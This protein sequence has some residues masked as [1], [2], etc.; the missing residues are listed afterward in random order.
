MKTDNHT[1]RIY[2]FTTVISVLLISCSDMDKQYTAPDQKS[3]FEQRV[4]HMEKKKRLEMFQLQEEENAKQEFLMKEMIRIQD[5]IN[6]GYYHLAQKELKDL[7]KRYPASKEAL[8]AQELLKSVTQNLDQSPVMRQ[9]EAAIITAKEAEATHSIPYLDE[10]E[11]YSLIKISIVKGRNKTALTS[12]NKFLSTF[13]KSSKRKEIEKLKS[14]LVTS[15]QKDPTNKMTHTLP[16]YL[17][18]RISQMNDKELWIESQRLI[19][20]EKYFTAILLL[21]HLI[22]QF[23]ESTYVTQAKSSLPTLRI[24]LELNGN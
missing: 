21:E 9:F 17:K 13:P 15:V 4:E 2:L 5:S 11:L 20:A 24:Q 7:I 23:P 12:I 1:N 18:E 8:K 19:E 10:K 3:E 6:K 14:K 16:E 22:Q